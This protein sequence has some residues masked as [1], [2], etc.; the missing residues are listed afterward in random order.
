[1]IARYISVTAQKE[2]QVWQ[3]HSV[4]FGVGAALFLLSM[5][6]CNKSD[7]GPVVQS[8]PPPAVEGSS[9]SPE[10]LPKN[11]ATGRPTGSS[12]APGSSSR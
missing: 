10:K 8:P 7:N 3:V 5:S 12:P 11:N 9:P 4:L 6:G 2:K 1:M